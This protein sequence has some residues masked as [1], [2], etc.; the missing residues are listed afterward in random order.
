M[1]IDDLVVCATLHV[2][3]KGGLGGIGLSRCFTGNINLA[4]A[5]VWGRVG[6]GGAR[7]MWCGDDWTRE[8]KSRSIFN[9]G[10]H[11]GGMVTCIHK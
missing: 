8:R 3:G 2:L 10:S 7:W 11:R 5:G 4:A 6:L 1:G 9:I